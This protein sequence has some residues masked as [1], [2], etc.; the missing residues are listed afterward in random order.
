MLFGEKWIAWFVYSSRYFEMR[1]YVFFEEGYMPGALIWASQEHVNNVMYIRYAESARVN[2]AYN[3]A[4]HL[5]PGHKK[6]WMES[7]TP[8]GVGMILKSMRTDYKFPM[9]WPDHISVF[10]KLSYLPSAT[11]F[12]FVLEVMI[13]SE[14]HQRP[15]A[16]C[17]ED[18]VVYDYKKG[19]KTTIKPFMMKAFEQTWAEQQAETA[20]VGKRIKELDSIVRE[21]EQNTWDREDAVEDMGQVR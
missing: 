18:I 7:V 1:V 4:V 6:E 9:T 12:S 10:H 5:D 15:A 8:N 21:I 13:I 3:Y 17:V 14:L 2:W 11:E 20:R 19:K 16:R